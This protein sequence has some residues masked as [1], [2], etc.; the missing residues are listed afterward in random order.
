MGIKER[1][2]GNMRATVAGFVGGAVSA[3]TLAT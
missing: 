1:V 2:I 3:G